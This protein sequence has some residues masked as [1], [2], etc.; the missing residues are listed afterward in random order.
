[1]DE[2]TRNLIDECKR[3]EE[4]CLYTSTTLFEWLKV[5]RVWKTVF[6]VVP[7]VFGSL[8]TWQLLAQKPDLVWLT[9]IS[10]LLAGIAPAVYKALDLDVSLDTIAK[11]AGVAKVLQDRYRQCWRVTA[12]GQF[13]EFKTE[14]DALTD[15]LDAARASSLTAPERYFKRA[16]KK[17]KSGDYD[18]SIDMEPAARTQIGPKQ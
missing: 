17:I 11:H 14:F 5:M 1:M 16:Q 4:S 10:S 2:R 9:A 7:I 8:A 6:V 3:L 18:F 12:H 15:R 13:D